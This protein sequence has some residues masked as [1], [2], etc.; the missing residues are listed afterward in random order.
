VKAELRRAVAL[1]SVLSAL[2]S[3]LFAGQSYFFCPGMQKAA[4]SCCCPES[5]SQDGPAISRTPCCDR[6]TLSAPSTPIDLLRHATNIPASSDFE[7]ELIR[8][9][10]RA[11]RDARDPA[12]EARERGARAGPRTELFAL[13]SV[14][15]I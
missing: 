11:P 2:A 4:K 5:P 9:L 3:V 6:T 1:L 10:D 8:I 12:V 13:H 15:L 14:Y 7:G